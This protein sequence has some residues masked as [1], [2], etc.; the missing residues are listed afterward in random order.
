MT[1]KREIDMN[2]PPKEIAD[3]LHEADLII[4]PYVMFVNPKDRS[5]IQEALKETNWNERIVIQEIDNVEI[6]RPL[7]AVRKDVESWFESRGINFDEKI[8]DYFN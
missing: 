5:R 2:K 4:R 8:Q 6:G 3:A 7:L 1:N